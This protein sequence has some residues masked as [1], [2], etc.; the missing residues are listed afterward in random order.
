MKRQAMKRQ[1]SIAAMRPPLRCYQT[2]DTPNQHQHAAFGRLPEQQ[3]QNAGLRANRR[4]PPPGA[5]ALGVTLS[6]TA[7]SRTFRKGVS[8]WSVAK[9]RVVSS[10][11]ARNGTSSNATL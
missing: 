8:G 10:R 5:S 9:M 6:T 11:P 2:P 1:A 7:R 3:N 4:Q